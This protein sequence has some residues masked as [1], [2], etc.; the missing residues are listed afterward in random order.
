VDTNFPRKANL[1]RRA[2][3]VWSSLLD[4]AIEFPDKWPF[5]TFL[6]TL[7]PA[8]NGASDRRCRE[9]QE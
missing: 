3:H 7:D 6:G 8:A 4:W 2:R 5:A 1:E 9:S